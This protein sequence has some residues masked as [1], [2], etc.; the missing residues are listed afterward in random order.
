MGKSLNA[1]KLEVA[2]WSVP[3][4]SAA[5]PPTMTEDRAENLRLSLVFLLDV[6]SSQLDVT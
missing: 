5:T 6:L 4:P 2:Q 3:T 1:I